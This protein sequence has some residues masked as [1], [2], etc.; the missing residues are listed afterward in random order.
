MNVLFQ[1]MPWLIPAMAC[2]VLAS[3]FFSASEAALFMLTGQERRQ[4]AQGS[5]G[6]RLAAGLLKD[7][8]R[9]LTAVLFWNLL[10]NITYFSLVAIGSLHLEREETTTEAGVF[11]FAALLTMILFSEML[12]KS[13]GLL[14]SRKWAKLIGVPVSLAVRAISHLLPVFRMANLLSRRVLFPR[15]AIE[16]YLEVTDLERA[17]ELSTTDVSILEQ[18]RAVLQNI[19]SLSEMRADEL[20]RPRKR[21]LSFHPPVSLHDLGGERP[22]SGYVLVTESDTDEVAGAIPLKQLYSIPSKNLESHAERVI[23]VP[24]CATVGDTFDQMRTRDRNVAAVVNEHGETIGILT[25][26]DILDTIFSVDVSRSERL[27]Q[28]SP[29][30]PD[31]DNAWRVTGMT[32]IRRLDRE[33]EI[34]LPET[35]CITVA[36]VV[37]ESLGRMPRVGDRC[38][39]GPF[40]F[41]VVEMHDQGHLVIAMRRVTSREEES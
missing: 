21:F 14:M 18:E 29:I 40:E 30:Q 22:P 35:K 1:E 10:I 39:W 16:P 41:E 13:V 4:M 34:P 2:L 31:G 24:W 25:R 15:F 12:P 37:Q 23:Y 6:E 20:M 27:L 17:V 19:V 38:Q 36:G 32:T 9:L 11:S 26:D 5:H 3:G 28:R 33:L 8:D 7:P